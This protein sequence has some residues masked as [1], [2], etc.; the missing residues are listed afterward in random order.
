[1]LIGPPGIGK[2]LTIAKLAARLA[3]EDTAKNPAGLAIITT[4]DKRAGGI[5]ATARLYRY[6]WADAAY[7]P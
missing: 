3:L 1:M 2:T 6:P 4:D 5:E 7:R